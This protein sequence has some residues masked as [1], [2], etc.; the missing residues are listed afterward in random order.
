[1]QDFN[2]D[3]YLLL[4]P[5][6]KGFPSLDPDEDTL[7]RSYWRKQMPMGS[8]PLIFINGFLELQREQGT[9]LWD[10]PPDV[11]FDGARPIVKDKIRDALLNLDIPNLVMNESI[12]IDH[13]EIWHENLWFLGFTQAL[14]CWDR[15]KS[16]VFGGYDPDDEEDGLFMIR[17]YVLNNEV[18]AKIPLQERLLF[19]IG[20]TSPG[21]IAA[22]Y[23]VAKYFANNTGVI[24]LPIAE[25]GDRSKPRTYI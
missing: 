8:A 1:M 24:V 10:T 17:R 5:N 13:N 9:K 2:Q 12:Y 19:E 7:N 6:G 11:M 25:Y 21:H 4:E 16:E 22:H 14:D 23:S 18:L 3:Y 15:E 20:N